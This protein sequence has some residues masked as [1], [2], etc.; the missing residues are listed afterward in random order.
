MASFSHTYADTVPHTTIEQPRARRGGPRRPQLPTTNYERGERYG[1]AINHGSH[2]P[3]DTGV[4][5]E[6]RNPLNIL[7]ALMLLFVALAL[8]ALVV[9]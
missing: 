8:I 6:W 4:H 5:W 1:P 2:M 3:L 9:R 7:P